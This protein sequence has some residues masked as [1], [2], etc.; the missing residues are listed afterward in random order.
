MRTYDP[1]WYKMANMTPEGIRSNLVNMIGTSLN[2]LFEPTSAGASPTSPTKTTRKLKKRDKLAE[3]LL[4]ILADNQQ[5]KQSSQLQLT[6][7]VKHLGKVEINAPKL[8]KI[9][10]EAWMKFV[11]LYDIYRQADGGE[12]LV[13]HI[14]PTSMAFAA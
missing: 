3:Q 11:E 4:Q 5:H 9:T 8:K 13:K 2:P 12:N 1:H 6:T 10:R 7:L 14:F